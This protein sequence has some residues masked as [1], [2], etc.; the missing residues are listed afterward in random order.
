[1]NTTQLAAAIKHWDRFNLDL[2]LRILEVKY[3]TSLTNKK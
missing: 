1:M 2:L 3:G